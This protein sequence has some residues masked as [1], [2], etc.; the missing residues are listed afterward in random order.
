MIGPR[1][2]SASEIRQIVMARNISTAYNSRKRADSVVT[3]E[4][5]NP[6]LAEIL[7]RV[8]NE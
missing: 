5:D 4:R 6:E 1:P 7:R 8:E 2:L 3:W